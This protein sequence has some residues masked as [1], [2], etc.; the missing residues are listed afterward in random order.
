MDDQPDSAGNDGTRILPHG[1][2][3]LSPLV[4]AVL[5]LPSADREARI[6]ELTD[7]DADRAATLR[8]LVAECERAMPQLDVPAPEWFAQLIADEPVQPLPDLRGDRYRIEREL[9]R[10]GMARVFLALDTK[11]NRQV[12]VKVIPPRSGGI[13][14]PRTVPA[15]DRDCGAPA[16]SEHRAAV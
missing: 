1:W 6:L 5:D 10:V 8:A 9:G 16:A 2:A 4:D 7:G 15:R 14:R 12:A 11:H 13:T 3:A